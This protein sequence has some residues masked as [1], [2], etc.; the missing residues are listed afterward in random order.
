MN[1]TNIRWG[2]RD[3]NVEM[4]VY[5]KRYYI[6]YYNDYIRQKVEV[7]LIAEKM[8]ESQLRT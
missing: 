6:G 5:N 2:G 4:N 8:V 1:N 3:E 7:V